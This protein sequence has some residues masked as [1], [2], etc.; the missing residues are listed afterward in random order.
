MVTGSSNGEDRGKLKKKFSP[1]ATGS[2]VE[3]LMVSS[4]LLTTLRSGSV[5]SGACT[6]SRWNIEG[7]G[8]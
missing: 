8:G 2:R 6:S 1:G 4:S 7:A 5:D 3:G